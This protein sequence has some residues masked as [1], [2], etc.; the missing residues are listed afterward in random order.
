MPISIPIW[1]WASESSLYMATGQNA[2]KIPMLKKHPQASVIVYE[3]PRGWPWVR[4]EGKA[5]VGSI[6]DF[7]EFSDLREAVESIAANYVGREKA[8]ERFQGSDW[9]IVKLEPER[10]INRVET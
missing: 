3:A 2:K 4:V 6:A 8:P 1:G 9:I 7:P 5:R 10:I